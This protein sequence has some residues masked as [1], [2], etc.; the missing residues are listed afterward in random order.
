MV[1]PSRSFLWLAISFGWPFYRVGSRCKTGAGAKLQPVQNCSRCKKRSSPKVDQMTCCVEAPRQS[2]PFALRNVSIRETSESCFYSAASP[3]FLEFFDCSS[4]ERQLLR[5]AI[6]GE[7]EDGPSNVQE[8]ESENVRHCDC[9][10]HHVLTVTVHPSGR[11]I[12]LTREL[13]AATTKCGEVA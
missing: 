4:C 13:R 1:S 10:G 3:V 2:T 9:D 11:A 5:I 12:T 8:K 6:S 7:S